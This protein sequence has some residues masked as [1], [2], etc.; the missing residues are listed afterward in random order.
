M[1]PDVPPLRIA[2]LVKQIPAFESMQLGPDGRLVRQG[3]LLEMSA[4][5][6]RAVAQAVLLVE[7]F[8]GSVTVVTMGPSSADDVL[9][10]AIAYAT[11]HGV[12]VAAVHITDAAFAGADTLATARAL[13]ATIRLLETGGTTFDLILTG[14]NSVDADTGQVGP[15]VAELLDRPFATGVKQLELRATRAVDADGDRE[16]EGVSVDADVGCEHDDTWVE[17]SVQ[18]PALLSTAER[19]IDPCKI[20]DPAVWASVDGSLIR[21]ISAADL[22]PGPWGAA[23]SPTSVGEIRHEIAER[24]NRVL[25]GTI[26]EQVG[27]VVDYLADHG[28]LVP[29][30]VHG[31]TKQPVPAARDLAPNAPFVVA[32]V[33]PKRERLTAEL[34]GAASRLASEIGGVVVAIGPAPLHGLRL[35]QW[36]AARAVEIFGAEAPEDVAAAVAAWLHANQPWAALA[37]STAWGRE[38]ASRAAAAVGAG[39][40]GDA[41]G[42][43]VDGGRLLAWKP[44]F[45]GSLVAAIHASSP[46]QMATVRPGMLPLFEPN[47]AGE[48]TALE[49]D[50]LDVLPRR[51]VTIHHQVREDNLDDLAT[52]E[53]VVGVGMGVDPARYGELD[54]LRELLGAELAATRKVTDNGW[55]P[56]ARQIGITGHSISPRLYLAIGMSGKY[57]HTVGVRSAGTI[58]AI[59]PDRDAPVFAFSDLGIVAAWEDVVPELERQLRARIG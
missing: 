54:G 30:I 51:R 14:R 24:E 17:A 41:V 56:R 43:A 52:A 31:E 28:L 3:L 47:A 13:D 22:G 12:D 19:L 58:V 27:E 6:R 55:Q 48:V 21:R 7:K 10:E 1:E 5:D 45:G 42:L 8:G 44:A 50:R 18:L 36:G 25:E 34:L 2:A 26:T 38:V 20:K 49:P 16:G 37:G 4:Y 39:L 59:N 35:A 46:I 33:E 11:E 15:Q 32:V 29:G 40:T 9:R 23:G 53:M 57:N